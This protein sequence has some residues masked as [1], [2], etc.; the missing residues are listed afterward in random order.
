MKLPLFLARDYQLQCSLRYQEQHRTIHWFTFVG[1][2]YCSNKTAH[3]PA[4]IAFFGHE[5]VDE[6]SNYLRY[7]VTINQRFTTKNHATAVGTPTGGSRMMSERSVS[8]ENFRHQ[9]TAGVPTF[10]TSL[11]QNQ[12]KLLK[13]YLGLWSS[14]L[15]EVL[16]LSRCSNLIC[17]HKAY[18]SHLPI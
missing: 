5:Y 17:H 8:I 2:T 14:R 4:Q 9:A 1:A 15:S 3:G 12:L 10:V 11:S 7:L 16:T 6:V 13:H 18:L